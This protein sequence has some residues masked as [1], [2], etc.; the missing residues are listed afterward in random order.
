MIASRIICIISL[1]AILLSRNTAAIGQ[2]V[3]PTS[4]TRST[5]LGWGIN[6]VFEET[7]PVLSGDGTKLYFGRKYCPENVGGQND[8]QDIWIARRTAGGEW[9]RAVN[10]G[11]KVNTS[12]ADNLCA[13][14]DK[15]SLMLYVAEANGYGRFVIRHPLSGAERQIGPRIYNGSPFLEAF[16]SDERDIILYTARGRKNIFYRRGG[17]ERDIY[18]SRRING[19]WSS[20]ENVGPMINS[21]SD[22]YSPWLSPDGKTL[23]FGATRSDSFGGVDIYYARRTGESWTQWEYPRN[24]GPS[25][26]SEGFDAYFTI[27]PDGKTAYI[28]SQKNT[29]GRGDII[30]VDIPA[31]LSENT[32]DNTDITFEDLLFQRG[33]SDLIETS[34][35]QLKKLCM[36]MIDHP[37]LEIELLGHTDNQGVHNSLKRL[38]EKRVQRVTEYLVSNGIPRARISA[39]SFGGSK[40]A[41]RNDAEENRMKN[42]RVEVV[43]RKM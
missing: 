36:L 34:A 21:A 4:Y 26:N 3:S 30:S 14:L 38:S 5:N 32:R 15:D 39:R 28:V 17:D 24:L 40:P 37:S 18:I 8:P 1:L 13:A 22:E 11:Q 20:P 16:I 35:E 31:V 43:I 9:T 2:G 6:S 23:F 29:Y 19:E 33:K 10:P 7:K 25:V 27:T 41:F 12:R 42:R